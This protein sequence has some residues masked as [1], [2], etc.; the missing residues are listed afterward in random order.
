MCVLCCVVLCACTVC[1][2][3]CVSCAVCACVHVYK[4]VRLHFC[5]Y[6]RLVV[7]LYD[8]SMTELVFDQQTLHPELMILLISFG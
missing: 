5:A 8:R 4:H 7:Q 3:V 2:H 6:N 1:M